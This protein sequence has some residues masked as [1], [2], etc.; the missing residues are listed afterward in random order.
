MLISK[1]DPNSSRDQL[2]VT[3]EMDRLTKRAM[4]K[5]FFVAIK[6]DNRSLCKARVK[7]TPEGNKT[8]VCV[9]K[10]HKIEA[11]LPIQHTV[12]LGFSDHP[13]TLGTQ[14]FWPLLTGGRCSEVAFAIK[15]ENVTP[16][17]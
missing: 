5:F 8:W 12:K 11:Y 4:S 6:L 3:A 14:N 9:Y 1:V 17:W 2:E 7:V 15:I 16:K 10:G 13:W